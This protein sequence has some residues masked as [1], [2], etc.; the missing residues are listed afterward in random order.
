MK[1]KRL[2]RASPPQRVR[3]LAGD[4]YRPREG[5]EEGWLLVDDGRVVDAGTGR[6]PQAPDATGFVLPAPVDAH[7]HV[8]DRVGRGADL[9]GMPLADVVKPPDGLKHRLLR[10]TP[11]ERL[12]AGMRDALA[13]LRGFGTRA[14]VDFREGGAEGVARLREAGDAPRAVVMARPRDAWDDAEAREVARVADGIG[15]S[16]LGDVASDVPERAARAARAEGKRFALHL[17]EDTRED[18]G[19]A[20]GLRPDFLVHLCEA[21]RD[22][23]RAAADARV[24]V[25]LCPRSNA[26]FGR[27][28]PAR[29]MLDLGVTIALGSDNAMFHELDVILDARHLAHAHPDVPH[30]T[31]L[32]AAI[33]GG[34]RVAD[35]AAPRS[36]LRKGDR[37]DVVVLEGRGLDAA[38]GA[39]GPRRVLSPASAH[40]ETRRHGDVQEG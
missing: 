31:W 29:A 8:G 30:E 26:L 25:V 21:T 18:M 24:P 27:A 1:D 38:F 13:E 4:V 5:I 3:C 32:D 33:V 10:E 15:L 14:F 6:P 2:A 40:A 34:A 39:R 16:A 37:A 17:S 11:R 36:W 22:D 12:V 19:R 23:L 28:P 7:T 9:S 20:L 35:G